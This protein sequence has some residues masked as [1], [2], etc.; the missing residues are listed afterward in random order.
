MEGLADFVPKLGLVR[1]VI[2]RPSSAGGEDFEGV[3][4]AVFE[5]MAQ[6]GVF[7]LSWQ[8]HGLSYGIPA[9]VKNHLEAGQDLL[10]NLSRGVLCEASELFPGLTILSVT[11]D[12]AVLAKRLADRG[13]ESAEEIVRRLDRAAFALPDG[14]DV[15]LLD[16]SGALDAT[17]RR[18]AQLLYPLSA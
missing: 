10:V 3:T 13:R 8:A 2:T 4:E 15:L 5:E 11:A 17:I 16:N 18:G 12:R 14:L 6:D 7:A 9:V 1:R